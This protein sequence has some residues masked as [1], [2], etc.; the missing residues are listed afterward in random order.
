MAIVP[1]MNRHRVNINLRM[2]TPRGNSHC[3]GLKSVL[4]L[5]IQG[6]NHENECEGVT[7]LLSKA[8]LPMLRK[9]PASGFVTIMLI[10]AVLGAVCQSAYSRLWQPWHA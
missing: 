5:F 10:K 2:A 8:I 6:I 1:I 3:I 4:T 7:N 9:S